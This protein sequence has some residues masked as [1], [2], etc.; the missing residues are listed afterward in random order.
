MDDFR[1]DQL[2]SLL[3]VGGHALWFGDGEEEGQNEQLDREV[4]WHEG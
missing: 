2:L 1:C 4:S 3:G